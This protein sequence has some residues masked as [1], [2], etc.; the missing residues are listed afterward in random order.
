MQ[1]VVSHARCTEV[2][3][4]KGQVAGSRQGSVEKQVS[5]GKCA[6]G[7]WGLPPR[8]MLACLYPSTSIYQCLLAGKSL[9]YAFFFFFNG[10]KMW[11]GG[12]E[13]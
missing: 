2:G 10:G 7:V 4:A 11:G 6:V 5:G 1:L 9:L 8:K 3:R 12:G 13:L